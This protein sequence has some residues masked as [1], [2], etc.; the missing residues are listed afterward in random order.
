MMLKMW[1]SCPIFMPL[2]S[3]NSWTKPVHSLTGLGLC[4][5]HVANVGNFQDLLQC[6]DEGDTTQSRWPP[7]QHDARHPQ[8]PGKTE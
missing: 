6:L 5:W 2:R 3:R 1:L 8:R 4:H 7:F